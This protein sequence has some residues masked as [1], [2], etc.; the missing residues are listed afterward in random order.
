MMSQSEERRFQD[1]RQHDDPLHGY[2]GN[3][4]QSGFG[5][6]DQAGGF[7]GQKLGQ[8]TYGGTASPG[9]R[10]ALAIVSVCLLVPLLALLIAVLAIL[11]STLQ[12]VGIVLGI[13]AFGMICLTIIIVNI[14][15]NI[16]R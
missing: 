2:I 16:R 13:S 14:T 12:G 11:Q 8:H 3:Q 4:Q 6:D 9:Q 1:S 15:F 5:Y 7:S 10:L